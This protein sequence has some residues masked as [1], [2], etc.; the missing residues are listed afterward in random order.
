MSPLLG[1]TDSDIGLLRGG[2]RIEPPWRGKGLVS[3]CVGCGYGHVQKE[4]KEDDID[5]DG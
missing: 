1:L 4:K 2:L 5:I 3:V